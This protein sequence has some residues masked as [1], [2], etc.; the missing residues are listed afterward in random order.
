[1]SERPRPPESALY[2]RR[3]QPGTFELPC[4][5]QDYLFDSSYDTL[6][7]HG[8]PRFVQENWTTNIA[9]GIL[10]NL[11]KNG[12]QRT[13]TSFADFEAHLK[14]HYASLSQLSRQAGKKRPIHQQKTA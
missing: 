12:S 3:T 7:K 6:T 1:M 14:E 8:I 10:P 13:F 5:L 9:N 11:D 4:D 2:R